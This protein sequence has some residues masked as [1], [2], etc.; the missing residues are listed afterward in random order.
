MKI[1]AV[2]EFDVLSDT[3]RFAFRIGKNQ[4]VTLGPHLLSPE[5]YACFL[6]A[7]SVKVTF[8]NT[9]ASKYSIVLNNEIVAVTTD[10]TY[11]FS[12]LDPGK[13]YKWYVLADS[14]PSQEVYYFATRQPLPKT[15]FKPPTI[16]A[17]TSYSVDT[18]RVSSGGGPLEAKFRIEM[19]FKIQLQ[20]D[21]LSV[22]YELKD[23][24]RDSVFSQTLH[25][26]K[27]STTRTISIVRED[28]LPVHYKIKFRAVD[29]KSGLK[30]EWSS[31]YDIKIEKPPEPPPLQVLPEKFKLYQNYPNPFNSETVI[32][33]DVPVNSEKSASKIEIV[34]YNLLGQPVKRLVNETKEP[35]TYEVTWDAKNDYGNPV[36]AGIYFYRLKTENFTE[37]K[38]MV[39][40]R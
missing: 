40:I 32:R 16:P 34:V 15:L 29:T 4:P 20:K 1:V 10:T 5:N 30:S 27:L 22:E 33:Y 6:D 24:L 3:V 11:T 36:S 12:G 17:I 35:G 21:Y 8:T 13:L 2:N 19:R 7:D 14:L 23:V 25:P 28:I 9:N 18:S 37:T 38:R 26:S 39:L 31:E